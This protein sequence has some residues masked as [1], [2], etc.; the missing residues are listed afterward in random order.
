MIPYLSYLRMDLG[1]TSQEGYKKDED[2]HLTYYLLLD[3]EIGLIIVTYVSITKYNQ[4]HIFPPINEFHDYIFIVSSVNI[5]YFTSRSSTY[6]SSYMKMTLTFMN[7]FLLPV[8]HPN[9]PYNKV[10]QRVL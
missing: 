1:M 2:S 10:S 6:V 9:C 8:N 3:L 4:N 7:F 5:Y